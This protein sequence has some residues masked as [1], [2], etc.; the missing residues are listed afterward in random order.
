MSHVV[1]PPV[2]SA[3]R[4]TDPHVGVCATDGVV[5]SRVV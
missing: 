3:G 1:V 5:D 2:V 4:R